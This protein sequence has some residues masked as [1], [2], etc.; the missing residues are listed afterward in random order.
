MN[1]RKFL[2][3]ILS[4]FFVVS[5]CRDDEEEFV[6]V[7]DRDRQEVADENDAEMLA[8]FETHFFNYEDFDFTN[9]TNPVNDD[10]TI[11]LDTISAENGTQDKTPLSFYL[12]NPSNSYPKLSSSPV[13]SPSGCSK[14]DGIPS[15][16]K[17]VLL[18]EITFKL[19]NKGEYCGIAAVG[20]KEK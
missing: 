8:Y 11:V 14:C 12:E 4:L 10:F 3:P 13:I 5:S 7:P 16:S 1:L 19:K 9:A 15:K 20:G 18:L 17:S 2:I 6:P